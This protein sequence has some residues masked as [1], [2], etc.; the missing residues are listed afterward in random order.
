MSVKNF[1]GEEKMAKLKKIKLGAATGSAKFGAVLFSLIL[2]GAIVALILTEVLN[3]E[4][5]LWITVGAIAV[6]V[7]LS[8]LVLR[9]NF[10]PYILFDGENNT[11]LFRHAFK[12]EVVTLKSVL[13]LHVEGKTIDAHVATNASEQEIKCGGTLKQTQYKRVHFK[14]PSHKDLNQRHRYEVFAKKCN[15]MLDEVIHR[16]EIREIYRYTP[17]TVGAAEK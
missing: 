15:K 1:K 5:L 4:E 14:M 7:I 11:L 9:V 3:F 8:G 13:K 16:K 2:V 17:E 12:K 10:A 6:V